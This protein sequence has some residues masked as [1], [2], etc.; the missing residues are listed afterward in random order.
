[1]IFIKKTIKRFDS[2]IILNIHLHSEILTFLLTFPESCGSKQD[3]KC[4]FM[5]CSKS[6]TSVGVFNCCKFNNKEK[7]NQQLHMKTAS[8]IE[9]GSLHKFKKFINS[10]PETA[11]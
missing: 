2:S 6:L 8:S 10:E 1:V 11:A 9:C 7:S 4:Y 5:I 3:R